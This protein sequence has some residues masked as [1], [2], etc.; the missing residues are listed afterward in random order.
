MTTRTLSHLLLP[1]LV[2]GLVS[3]S[4]AGAKAVPSVTR[5]LVKAFSKNAGR[6]AASL[7]SRMARTGIKATKTGRLA[8]AT[9]LD[10]WAKVSIPNPNRLGTLV[11]KTYPKASPMAEGLMKHADVDL[12]L[13]DT[14]GNPIVYAAPLQNQAVYGAAT[15]QFNAHASSLVDDVLVKLPNAKVSSEAELKA[16]VERTIGERATAQRPF[17][18]DTST[19]QITLNIEFDSGSQIVG[20]VNLYN[21][22]R[23]GVVVGAGG[24]YVARRM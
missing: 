9:H 16:L 3:C 4:S 15:R 21:A 6:N 5:E 19:G 2:L 22:L 7:S 14:V 23:S 18:F 20:S 12:V 1:V 8:P 13:Y 24:Y 17:V 10:E 11:N